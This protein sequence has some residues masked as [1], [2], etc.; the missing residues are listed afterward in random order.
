[1][2]IFVK[3]ARG[4]RFS[5][6]VIEQCF[7][8]INLILRMTPSTA[9]IHPSLLSFL[10]AF[11]SHN[12]RQYDLLGGSLTYPNIKEL[13]KTIARDLDMTDHDIVW[14]MAQF[15]SYLLY[16][17]LENVDHIKGAVID[18]SADPESESYIA[19]FMQIVKQM[20]GDHNVIR[21]LVSML[22]MAA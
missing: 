5:L 1:L 7:T 22:N 4:Y 14:T 20:E 18:L 8:E 9:T 13:L 12:P 3:L 16:G 21:D 6:R 17:Y 2:K 15:A 19:P 10:I 11:K